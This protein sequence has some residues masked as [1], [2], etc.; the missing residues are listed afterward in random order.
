[1]AAKTARRP[2]DDDRAG[3]HLRLCAVSRAERPVDDLI[4]F[5]AAP[6]GRITPDLGRKLPG[7]GVWVTAD[8]AS[9]EAA[10]KARAF[11]RSLKRAVTVAPELAQDIEDLL[12]KR[13]VDALSL[14]NK[15]GAVLAGFDKVR[16]ALD[17]G[18]IDLLVHGSDAASDGREK[19]DRKFQAVQGARSQNAEFSAD[20]TIAQLSLAMGRSNVVHAALIY[21]GVTDRFKIA[22]GRLRRY[23]S[24]VSL[25]VCTTAS[26]TPA[27]SEQV[28]TDIA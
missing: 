8:R 22:A 18:T 1:V 12:T 21:G 15:A 2:K 11:A 13:A 19:L 17:S 27:P 16:E 6:D 14:A 10:I 5:V 26:E 7:R 23:R 4:R 20:L 3:D 25:P 9:V 28:E 24:G